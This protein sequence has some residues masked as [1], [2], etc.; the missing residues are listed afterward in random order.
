[1]SVAQMVEHLNVA[2]KVAGSIPVRHPAP[3]AQWPVQLSCKQLIRVRFL[4][5][6]LLAATVEAL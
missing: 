4:V 6:A 3:V 2:Q 1:M 5:G